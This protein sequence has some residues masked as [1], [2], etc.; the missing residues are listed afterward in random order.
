M[1]TREF[2]SDEAIQQA[3]Q[4]ETLDQ[5]EKMG[6]IFLELE[7]LPEK[8]TEHIKELFR[9]AHS[10]KG[11]SG[12]V[13]LDVLKE[14]MHY[15]E[16]VFEQVRSGQK[17]LTKEQFG[18]LLQVNQEVYAF[19][20]D[21]HSWS[22]Q[23]MLEPW[24]KGLEKEFSNPAKAVESLTEEPL[25][26]SN[27]E[28]Q[29]ITFWQE[30]NKTVYGIEVDYDPETPMKGASAM[31]FAKIL[32]EYGTIFKMIPPKE[33][34]ASKDFNRF[35]V[36]LFTERELKEEEEN[37][38]ASYSGHG[39][40]AVQ[41]RKWAHRNKELPQP[42]KS[43][44]NPANNFV[45]VDYQKIIK[46]YSDLDELLKIKSEMVS[47]YDQGNR[48][49]TNWCDLGD[50]LFKMEQLIRTF[51]TDVLHLGMIP[52]KQ[53]F[54]RFPMIIRD[55]ARKTGK[56]VEVIFSGENTEIDKRIAEQLIDPLTHLIR[57]AVDHGLEN[58]EVR[59]S[60][61]KDPVGKIVM[62]AAVEGEMMLISVSDDGKG[63]DPEKI[64]AK[65]IKN[66]LINESD[67]V[68]DNDLIRLIFKP[69]FSTAEQVSE[70]SGRGVGLD[71][72][73]T[74]IQTLKGKID[75]LSR[76]NQGT[77]F[78]LKVPVTQAVVPIFFVAARG[79]YFG[80]PLNDVVEITNLDLNRTQKTPGG[81]LTRYG[82]EMI[83]LLDLG[84]VHFGADNQQTAATIPCLIVKVNQ[85]KMGILV[86]EFIG[87]E[88]VMLKPLAETFTDNAPISGI[89]MLSSGKTALVLNTGLLLDEDSVKKIAI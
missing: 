64:R 17:F 25:T 24:K 41:L 67:L 21:R 19:I 36:I 15:L 9:I 37:R 39:E 3:Y 20:Y 5:L 52:A 33:D 45:R 16:N 18:F 32:E 63:L 44:E 55:I 83:S 60:L 79:N 87:E 62:A 72:V 59:R 28:V 76:R 31:L 46:L 27:P 66:G 85:R 40:K 68:S 80:I 43:T 2:I 81:C 35:K 7:T 75:V 38:I 61:G 74:N 12:V 51:Q 23:L 77:I 1:N 49:N 13:G 47:F 11:A 78:Q 89:V 86:E 70:I 84:D 48:I 6:V 53:L 22:N 29:E 50:S 58:A 57:N 42:P 30:S 73:D 34:L 4:A 71:V 10:I 82:Q 54:S 69:G 56:E 65:A 88:K 26:L 8:Q 14:M